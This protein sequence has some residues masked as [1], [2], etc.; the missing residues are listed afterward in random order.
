MTPRL[1]TT[2]TAAAELRRAGHV[3]IDR[4]ADYLADIEQ[5]P[6]STPRSPAELAA[7]FASSLPQGGEPAEEVWDDVWSE[8]A[9]DSIHLAHP[10]YMGHQVAPP[11]PH[12]VLA[13]A[14]ASLLNQ[15]MAVQEMS[16]AATFVEGE[17]IRWLIEVLGFPATADGTLVS[18]GSA[19]NLTGL[20]AAREAAFPGIWERGIAGTPGAERAAFLVAAH[21]HYSIERAAGIMGFG[22]DAVVPVA[23]LSGKM[24]VDALEMEIAALRRHGRTPVAIVATAGSTA[25]GHFDD[26][27]SIA[28]VAARAGVWLHVDGAHGASFLLSDRL[29]PLLNGIDRVDSLAWDPHKMMF[30]PSS[31]GAIFVRD[32]RHLDA[33]FRQS[34]PYLFHPRPGESRSR[35]IGKRTLQ[36]S[37]RFDALK[38]WVCMRH[39]GTRHFAM[40]I[41]KTVDTTGLLYERL[42]AAP[43]F[44][45]SH[46]PESNI[47]CFRYIPDALRSAT[48]AAVDEF[49][50]ALRE[51]YNA[52]GQGWITSTVL[53][54]RRV[55][56]VTIMNPAT[57]QEH[58]ERLITGL[59]EEAG[60]HTD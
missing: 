43:D 28:D 50:G 52:S 26:L 14:M 40:L 4:M 1:S 59:R 3:L 45:P 11:L 24:D 2:D 9:A 36:C 22:S 57:G 21:A 8:V 29:R 46:V 15:S 7:R 31:A 58:V 42:S 49:Q 47:L 20:M 19:A 51:R 6:V 48:P 17:V 32:H 39:Y 27:S 23:E 41:E 16:P 35:D 34:A 10:M 18:G 54:G 56:R 33:A 55:L 25:T 60:K 13:D 12:A 37:R 44:E 53:A 38:L 5:L 30:M